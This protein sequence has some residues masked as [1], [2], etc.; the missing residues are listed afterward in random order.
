MPTPFD[1]RM[2]MT[3]AMLPMHQV[4]ETGERVEVRYPDR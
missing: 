2:A 4:A 1:E 3:R